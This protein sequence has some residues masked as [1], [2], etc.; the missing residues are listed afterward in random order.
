MVPAGTP[1]AIIDRLVVEVQQGLAT[2][3]LRKHFEAIGVEVE[4]RGPDEFM[5]LLRELWGTFGA[6]IRQL[7]I[8]AE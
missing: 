1:K 4:G 3:A 5:A 7:G 8:R 2:P 6:L